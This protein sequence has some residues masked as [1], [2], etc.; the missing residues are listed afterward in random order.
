MLNF[1]PIKFQ[2]LPAIVTWLLVVTVLGIAAT[3]LAA[4]FGIASRGPVKG[5]KGIF[6]GIGAAI[7][8]MLSASPRRIGALAKLTIKEA[9]RRKTLAIFAVFA[10][11]FMFGGWFLSDAEQRNALQVKVY[12]SFVLTAIS[13]LTLIMMLILACWGVPE[14]IRLR[15]MHTVVTKPARRFE[16]LLGRIIGYSIVGLFVLAVMGTVAAVW[17]RRQVPAEA[18]GF[19]AGRVPVWGDLT[20]IDRFGRPS[21]AGINVG[22]IWQHRSYIEGATKARAVWT[23]D[24]VTPSRVGDVLRIESQFESFRSTKGRDMSKGLICQYT[25][26]RDRPDEA[27]Q[28]LSNSRMLGIATEQLRASRFD[29]AADKIIEAVEYSRSEANNP[30]PNADLAAMRSGFEHAVGRLSEVG[31]KGEWLT[32]TNDQMAAVMQIADEA[33]QSDLSKEQQLE[34][35]QKVHAEL[36]RLSEVI[37]KNSSKLREFLPKLNVPLTPFEVREYRQGENV[38]EVPLV[39]D[40]EGSDEAVVRYLARLFESL[41]E[42]GKLVSSGALS[43]ETFD[44]LIADGTLTP[45]NVERLQESFR[46]LADDGFVS[47]TDSELQPADGQS[48][49]GLFDELLAQGEISAADGWRLKADLFEDLVE[50]GKLTVSVACH[51]VTQYVGMA[52]ADLF[53]RLADRSFEWG[54]AKAILTIAMMMIIIIAIG[55]TASC[56]VKGPVAIMLTTV[57]V[58]IGMPFHGF[59]AE[60][61]T[62]K[63]DGGGQASSIHRIFM[64]MNPMTE[65]EG[66]TWYLRTLAI[67]DNI[68]ITILWVVHKVIP[69]FTAFSRVSQYVENG[70]DVPWETA[71]LPCIAMTFAFVIP[72]LLVGN[73][74]LKYRELESR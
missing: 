51:S 46:L 52:K 59:L 21:R 32:E 45:Q 41:Q 37:R 33:R 67:I 73:F 24:G 43:A 29:T 19:L 49:F 69:D 39:I 36:T 1:N 35:K 22:D 26:V 38:L 42:E 10:V 64:H 2:F 72:C 57:I 65:I 27:F 8:D 70:F 18:Q 28:R 3:F 66:A 48:F 13:W 15:S 44:G 11:L 40:Y 50:D 61:V 7:S 54:F 58:V 47:F 17:V 23:F 4:L 63:L 34:Y 5:I 71:L 55:V 6:R 25:L 20:F 9:I 56:I 53:L 60:H 16:I 74:F 31:G 62:G 68:G 14:D 30:I 12:I